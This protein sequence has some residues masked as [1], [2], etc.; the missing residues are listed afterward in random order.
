MKTNWKATAVAAVM[1][2]SLPMAAFA[3]GSVAKTPMGDIPL[4]FGLPADNATIGKLYDEMDFQRATQA[5]I[6][7]MPIVG[8]A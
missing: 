5:Y 6:W 1:A 7:A 4:S 8:F 3:G 2:W